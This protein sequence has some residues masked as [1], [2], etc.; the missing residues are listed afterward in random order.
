MDSMHSLV[1]SSSRLTMPSVRFHSQQ[2][3]WEL[4]SGV[5]ASRRWFCQVNWWYLK[6][7]F[8]GF[9]FCDEDETHL[10]NLFSSIRSHLGGLLA[11]TSAAGKG[12]KSAPISGQRSLPGH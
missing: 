2:G 11:Q 4:L 5:G 12:I 10:V 8:L 9:C 7:G 3:F 1:A 6:R